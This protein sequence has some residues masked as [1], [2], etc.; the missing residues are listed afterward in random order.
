MAGT[1]IDFLGFGRG[2]RKGKQAPVWCPA[3]CV[4]VNRRLFG[5]LQSA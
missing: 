1:R 3:I 5:V 2:L 4:R